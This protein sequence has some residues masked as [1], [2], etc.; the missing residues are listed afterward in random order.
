MVVAP[1]FAYLHHHPSR[2]QWV[3]GATAPLAE[4][5]VQKAEHSDILA[6]VWLQCGQKPS[7][8]L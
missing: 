5:S 1:P 6:T 4:K 3:F 2:W 7:I 8:V